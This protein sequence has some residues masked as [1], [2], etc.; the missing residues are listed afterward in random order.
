[1]GAGVADRGRRRRARLADPVAPRAGRAD[2]AEL[3][4][5]GSVGPAD[6][7]GSGVAAGDHGGGTQTAAEYRRRAGG[8]FAQHG[9]R[10]GRLHAP[11]PGRAGASERRAR[12][13]EEIVPDPPLSSGRN[14]RAHR[15]PERPAAQRVRDAPRR[16]PEAAERRD[17]GFADRRGGAAQRWRRQRRR[18]RRGHHQRAARAPSAGAYSGLRPRACRA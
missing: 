3:A 7:D 8:R 16:Q 5:V 2:Y 9:D 6:A 17:I 18:H 10:R 1:M 12:R 14:S 4:F 11:V 13:T 15:E